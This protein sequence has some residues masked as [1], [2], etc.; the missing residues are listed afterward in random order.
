MDSTGDDSIMIEIIKQGSDIC[1]RWR[2]WLQLCQMTSITTLFNLVSIQSS[3]STDFQIVLF[4]LSAQKSILFK[5]PH[6]YYEN[7]VI[8][9]KQN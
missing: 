1:R 3:N 5:D 9:N 7:G 4:F 2:P 8:V 6:H